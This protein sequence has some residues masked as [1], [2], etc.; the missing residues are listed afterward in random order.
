MN[1]KKSHHT[2][3]IDDAIPKLHHVDIPIAVVMNTAITDKT[4]HAVPP[5]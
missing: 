5:T 4:K 2:P 3:D 1:E